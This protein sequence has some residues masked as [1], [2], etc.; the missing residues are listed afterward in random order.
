MYVMEF[1]SQN[2]TWAIVYLTL[3]NQTQGIY[4]IM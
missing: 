2:Q 1:L 3:Q 4:D